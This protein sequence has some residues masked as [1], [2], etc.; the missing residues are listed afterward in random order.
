[1]HVY[2]WG[3]VYVRARAREGDTHSTHAHTRTC[4]VLRR[5]RDEVRRNITAIRD[6]AGI[7]LA[8][9]KLLKQSLGADRATIVHPSAFDVDAEGGGSGKQAKKKKK[10]KQSTGGG[11]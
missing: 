4:Q 8:G 6:Q 11:D 7:N 2:I 10:R 9:L 1:M 3:G 5:L